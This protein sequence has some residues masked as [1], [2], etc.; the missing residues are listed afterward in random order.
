MKDKAN[1]FT[2][3]DRLN[4]LTSGE[5]GIILFG[6]DRTVKYQYEAIFKA[7]TRL[8]L[9]NASSEYIFNFEFFGKSNQ[10]DLIETSSNAFN[11]VFDAT[12]KLLESN[13]KQHT[14]LT[15]DA[16]GVLI[17]IR[18]NNQNLRIMQRRRIPGLDTFLNT[19]NMILWPRFQALIDLHIQ[20]LK[21]ASI[22]R[23]LPSKDTHPHYVVRRYAEFSVS[24]L[25]LNQGYD[26]TNIFYSLNRLRSEVESLMTKMA[27]EFP[28]KRTAHIFWINNIDLV[29]S[30][31]AEHS[32][33][34]L[35]T[36]KSYF[37]SLLTQKTHEF[38]Q[39][40]KL[41]LDFIIELQPFLGSLIFLLN[42]PQKDPQSL[43][44]ISKEFNEKW[45]SSLQSIADSITL[46]FPNF[47]NGARVLHIALTQ[48]VLHY[49]AFISIVDQQKGKTKV[50]P[51][52]IQTVLVEIK[53]FKSNF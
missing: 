39:E 41:T 15:F 6:E 5:S 32:Q 4:V 9:D 20:S 23:L 49:K 46:A 42:Q 19:I 25:T 45:K 12:F 43:D 50:T 38:V 51:V 52:G 36:E 11:G 24:I 17:C 48:F 21:T 14:D 30:I 16:V 7:I 27:A 29:I 53:K 47:Q 2:L 1:I 22:S 10:T 8:V 18:L 28:N 3:G 26:E 40:G 13:F 35:D 37:D 31:L 34:S 33:S 44:F